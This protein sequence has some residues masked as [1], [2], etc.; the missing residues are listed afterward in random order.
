MKISWGGEV[1]VGDVHSDIGVQR[2]INLEVG[3]ASLARGLYSVL[4]KSS[5]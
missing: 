3:R 4:V 2:V 1:R 5:L